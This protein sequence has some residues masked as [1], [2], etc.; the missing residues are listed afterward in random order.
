MTRRLLGAPKGDHGA[1]WWG[2][3]PFAP[4]Q[5]DYA[6]YDA[7]AL[8]ELRDRALVLAEEFGCTAQVLAASAP[9]VSRPSAVCHSPTE[10]P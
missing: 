5:L 7:V 2:A 6:A 9:P 10:T 8:L 4:A 3:E 1:D